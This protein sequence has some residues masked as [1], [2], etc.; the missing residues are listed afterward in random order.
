[1]K[2]KYPKDMYE[3]SNIIRFHMPIKVNT[4]K[5][6]IQSILSSLTFVY[7]KRLKFK[8]MLAR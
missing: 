7:T 3:R 4:V 6:N 2:T 1:M 5:T 8:Q